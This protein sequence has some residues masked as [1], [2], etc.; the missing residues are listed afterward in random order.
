[1]NCNQRKRKAAE[2]KQLISTSAHSDPRE[3]IIFIIDLKTV[4]KKS[5]MYIICLARGA[6]RV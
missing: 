5:L 4:A 1:M 2:A 6:I 3:H